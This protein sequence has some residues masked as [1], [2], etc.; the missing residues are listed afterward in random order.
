MALAYACLGPAGLEGIDAQ[1]PLDRAQRAAAAGSARRSV[2]ILD[3]A[4]V[5]RRLMRPGDVALDFTV[6][7]ASLRAAVGDT[8]GAVRELDLVLDALPTLGPFAV[9]EE[10]QAAA[11]GRAL[12]LRAE[13]AARNGDAEQRRRR[14]EQA[15]SLWEHADPPLRPSL[16]RLRQL[17][18][19]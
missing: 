15:L 7:E 14:A 16:T 8:S 17:A 3:S 6:Q 13:L 11:V 10:A 9:R 5:T 18:A 19:P 2:R 4:L 12:V 1:S